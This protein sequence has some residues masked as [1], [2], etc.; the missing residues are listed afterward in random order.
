MSL[1]AAT[2]DDNDFLLAVFASTR[3]DELAGLAWDPKQAEAF[4]RMQCSAQQQNYRASYPA[5]ENKIIFI[6][7]RRIGRMLVERSAGALLLV[8]IAVLPEYRNAGIGTALLQGLLSEA[9]GAAKPVRLHV[10]NHNPAVRLYE[11]L[12]FSRV[13]DDGVYLEMQWGG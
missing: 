12:G 1:R 6:G 8:D 11:R 4:I 13:A 7:D 2:P 10:L 9:A 3:G 5:A